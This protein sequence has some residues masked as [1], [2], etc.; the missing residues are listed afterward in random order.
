M[1]CELVPRY[2]FGS[3]I[4]YPAN[5]GGTFC[6]YVFDGRIAVCIILKL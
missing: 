5:A 3:F 4:K 6:V 1:F 2:C